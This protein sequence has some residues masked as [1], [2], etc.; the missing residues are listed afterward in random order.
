[1]KMHF[2]QARRLVRCFRTDASLYP[3]LGALSVAVVASA[4]TIFWDIKEEDTLRIRKRNDIFRG[5]AEEHSKRGFEK[6]NHEIRK[7]AL[8]RY[9]AQMEKFGI[10][11]GDSK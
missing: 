2:T 8:K 6:F 7:N 1:M 3:L 5:G 11:I 10:P 4:I 9:E